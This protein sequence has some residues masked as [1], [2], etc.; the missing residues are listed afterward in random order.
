MGCG[1]DLWDMATEVM[2]ERRLP[3]PPCCWCCC[4]KYSLSVVDDP[5]CKGEPARE[6]SLLGRE[7]M[8]PSRLWR[9]LA[10]PVDGRTWL[11]VQRLEEGVMY[12]Y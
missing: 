9:E 4:C 2:L 6:L 8:E 1:Q 10:D 7:F 11:Y 3:E 12:V 5:I